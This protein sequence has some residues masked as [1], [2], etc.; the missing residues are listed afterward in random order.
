MTDHDLDAV[1][2]IENR[3]FPTPWSKNLFREEM[4]SPICR[5]RIALRGGNLLGYICF[6]LVYDEVHLRNLAVDPRWRRR[7]VGTVLIDDMFSISL[8]SG[9]RFAL[10]EVRPS[11]SGAVELYE[12]FGF[13]VAGLRKGYYGDTGEDAIVMCADLADYGVNQVI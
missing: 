7:R 13:G 8:E 6:A 10:L 4:A 5:N 9:C 1:M 2:R 11:N 12:R 3:S